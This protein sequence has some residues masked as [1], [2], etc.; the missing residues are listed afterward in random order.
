MRGWEQIFF[1]DPE[2]NVIE[3]HQVKSDRSGRRLALE[4][5]K[6]AAPHIPMPQNSRG[7]PC[8]PA[9]RLAAFAGRGCGDLRPPS[10]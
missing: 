10:A 5:L 4:D 7:G 2:G 8:P 3:V 9:R 1:H 6:T